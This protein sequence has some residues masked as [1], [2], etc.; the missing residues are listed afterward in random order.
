M[1]VAGLYVKEAVSV[2]NGEKPLE[3]WSEAKGIGNPPAELGLSWSETDIAK[4]EV[5]SSMFVEGLNEKDPVSA[6]TLLS[7][8]EV[9]VTNRG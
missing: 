4:L 7:P 9:A 8:P 5:T 3:F 6:Y 1:F 2:N